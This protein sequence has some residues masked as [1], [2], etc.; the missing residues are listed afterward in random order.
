[1]KERLLVSD[2][3][4]A[5]DQNGPRPPI[6]LIAGL[7]KVGKTFILLQLRDSY[8]DSVYIDCSIGD[9]ARNQLEGFMRNPHGVL[10]LDEVTTLKEYESL[11]A[12]LYDSLGGSKSW[13]AKAV[14]TAS[15]AAHLC[16]LAA[17]KLGGGRS[18]IF[19]L[20]PITFVE[21]L[22]FTDKIPDFI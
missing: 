10:L 16:K 13:K 9:K 12:A 8:V 14:I 11:M 6:I 4:N 19:Y 18:T 15:S 20:P 17:G 3:K 7:R 5:I 2:V 22:Y 1:M 21:Y